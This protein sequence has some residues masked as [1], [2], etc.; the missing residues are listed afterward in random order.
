M[1]GKRKR[2]HKRYSRRVPGHGKHAIAFCGKRVNRDEYNR[3]C[4]HCVA[5][6]EIQKLNSSM[7]SQS[8]LRVVIDVLGV[9]IGPIRPPQSPIRAPHGIAPPTVVLE[10]DQ[11]GTFRK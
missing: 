11:D 4:S 9:I 5:C 10:Q 3:H 1:P 2:V 8:M 6:V 7:A